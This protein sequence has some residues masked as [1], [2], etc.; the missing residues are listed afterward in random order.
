MG[1]VIGFILLGLVFL[2]GLT[3]FCYTYYKR[4]KK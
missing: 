2:A 1:K 3:Q 4:N